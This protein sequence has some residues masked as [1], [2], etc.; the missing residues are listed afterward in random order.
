MKVVPLF[1]LELKFRARACAWWSLWAAQGGMRASVWRQPASR[2]ALAAEARAERA[3]MD[4]EL[5]AALD[6]A[7]GPFYPGGIVWP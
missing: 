2:L 1:A 7:L 5:L 6:A 3:R 4:A